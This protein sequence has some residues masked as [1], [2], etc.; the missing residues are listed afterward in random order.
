MEFP[1]R[2]PLD[3]L[4][5]DVF[6]TR[7]LSE[8]DSYL[9]IEIRGDDTLSVVINLNHPHIND[10]NGR[11][12]VLNHLKACTYEGVAQW[13]VKAAWDD[14]KPEL[15]RAIKDALLRVGPSVSDPD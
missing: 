4:V 3:G 2:Y 14:D 13:K 12:G 9:G 6:L 11:I 7:Q 8:R 1:A 5:L 15:I 10:L